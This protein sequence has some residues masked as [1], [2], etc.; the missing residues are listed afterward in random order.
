MLWTGK[1]SKDYSGYASTRKPVTQVLYVVGAAYPDRLSGSGGAG[2]ASLIKRPQHSPNRKVWSSE[3]LHILELRRTRNLG[4]RRIQ[5]ELRRH[6]DISL[7]LATIHKVL[8]K[9]GV[10]PLVQDRQKSGVVRYERPVP[11]DRI[12]MDTCKI[13]PIHCD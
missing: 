6:V 11:G 4:A 8:S 13:G 12:Q 9:R 2:L 1:F 5:S 3:E 10:K 7:A